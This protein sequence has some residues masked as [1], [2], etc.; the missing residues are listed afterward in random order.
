MERYLEIMYNN[1]HYLIVI[2]EKEAG[3]KIKLLSNVL[4]KKIQGHNLR[5]TYTLSTLPPSQLHDLLIYASFK[6]TVEFDDFYL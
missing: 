6:T 1:V 5:D 4:K 2:H 3:G